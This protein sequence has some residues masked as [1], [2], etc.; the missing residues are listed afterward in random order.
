M[1]QSIT[2]K[3]NFKEYIYSLKY[4]RVCST[5]EKLASDKYMKTTGEK[6]TII[7][8]QG[9]LVSKENLELWKN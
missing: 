5:M 8:Q 2:A 4:W 6:K 1:L 7:F 9:V 3:K